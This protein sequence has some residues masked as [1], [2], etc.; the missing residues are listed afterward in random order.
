MGISFS[1][2]FFLLFFN[3]FNTNI[4]FFF[5]RTKKNKFLWDFYFHVKNQKVT[6]KKTLEST[7]FFHTENEQDLIQESINESLREVQGIEIK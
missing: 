2:F 3:S 4:I 7:L 1:L 6:L 5:F